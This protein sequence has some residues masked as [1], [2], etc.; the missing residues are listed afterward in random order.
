[1]TCARVYFSSLN[2]DGVGDGMKCLLCWCNSAPLPPAGTRCHTGLI[3]FIAVPSIVSHGLVAQPDASFDRIEISFRINSIVGIAARAK[4][5]PNAVNRTSTV[6]VSKRGIQG[7]VRLEKRAL[8]I[9]D[10]LVDC[11]EPGL[12]GSTTWITLLARDGKLSS[13]IC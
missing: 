5:S 3:P 11:I 13:R 12:V 8:R 1:M 10:A 7:P 2:L 4:N 9:E 6:F